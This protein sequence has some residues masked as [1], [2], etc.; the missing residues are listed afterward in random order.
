MM[1]VAV[2]ARILTGAES[3]MGRGGLLA[4]GALVV[5]WAGA[6]GDGGSDGSDAGKD[7]FETQDESPLGDATD[8]MGHQDPLYDLGGDDGDDTGADVPPLTPGTVRFVHVSDLHYRGTAADP[9]A[10]WLKARI[11]W[12]NGLT[13]SPDFVVISGDLCDYLGPDTETDPDNSRLAVLRG[14]LDEHLSLPWYASIGNHEFYD[15][16]EP[17]VITAD[18][19]ARRES[20]TIFQEEEKSWG[21]WD[22]EG[23]RFVILDSMELD[24]WKENMG[25]MGRFTGEQIDW[26][27]EVLGD[28]MPTFLFFHHPPNTLAPR[29][30][31][32]DLCDVLN[33]FPGQVKGLFTGHLHGFW[34]GEWC[35]TPYF[36]VKDWRDAPASWYEVE[37]DGATDT[38]TLLNEAD[39]PFVDPPEVECTPGQDP[40][41][42]MTAAVGT[43]QRFR[44]T[45]TVTDSDGLAQYLGEALGEIPFMLSID[46][47]DDADHELVAR[48]TM[49]SRWE[50]DG[51]LTYVEGA[52]CPD[53]TLRLHDPC[54]AAGPASVTVDILNFLGGLTEEPLNP[55]WRVR[56][57]I[58]NLRVEGRMGLVNGIP[59]LEEGVL[60]ATFEGAGAIAD[61]KQILVVEYCNGRLD[62]CEPGSGPSMPDCPAQ[63]DSGF[64]D[65][66]PYACDIEIQGLGGRMI[67]ELIETVPETVS[68]L[69]S[70]TTEVIPVS[71]EPA[72]GTVPADLF[73]TDPG[74][75]CEVPP[76]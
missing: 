68:V 4:L 52:P 38:L 72:P 23:V 13:S 39:L 37:Y 48:L 45:N 42:D 7:A 70:I 55:E 60:Y 66:I 41:G 18:G 57:D 6:C 40:L 30:G 75:N 28:G 24:S 51:L 59:V 8:A 67:I 21:Y 64:F 56:L 14:L 71:E 11:D 3:L 35:G 22:V 34:K 17:P 2:R 69:G 5:L 12:I 65:E 25:L 58:Q 76:A 49:A 29:D 16:F 50:S 20:F 46:S 9:K 15:E 19:E 54:V 74:Y 36:V 31:D 33:D 26:L 10:D 53:F 27:R 47:F 32:P 61:L 73:S 1:N 43:V 44:V 63:A 62:G